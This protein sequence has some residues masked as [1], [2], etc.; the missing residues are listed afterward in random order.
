MQPCGA[1]EE[2]I[3]GNGRMKTVRCDSCSREFEIEDEIIIKVCVCGGYM[4]EVKKNG[5][6]E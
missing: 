2:K 5:E 1:L 4:E 6:K 3:G